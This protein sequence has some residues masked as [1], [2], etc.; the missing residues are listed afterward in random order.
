MF[1]SFFTCTMFDQIIEERWRRWSWFS[2]E[3]NDRRIALYSKLFKIQKYR[4]ACLA[5]LVYTPMLN[6]R[7]NRFNSFPG[8]VTTMVSLARYN[9]TRI[10]PCHHRTLGRSLRVLYLVRWTLFETPKA[11]LKN[12]DYSRSMPMLRVPI[13]PSVVDRGRAQRKHLF[14]SRVQRGHIRPRHD[15]RCQ[16][17]T[18]SRRKTLREHSSRDLRCQRESERCWLLWQ[19]P[20]GGKCIFSPSNA[21]SAADDEVFGSDHGK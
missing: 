11:S 20:R 1:S 12:V 9:Q 6:Q 2:N 8:K 15:S 7:E 21:Q 5:R 17:T 14:W 16:S 13:F 3:E 10:Q 18:H 19:C 4:S